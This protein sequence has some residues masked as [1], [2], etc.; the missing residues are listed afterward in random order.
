MLGLL[1][2]EAD[3]VSHLRRASCLTRN[4]HLHHNSHASVRRL[5]GQGAVGSG[6]CHIPRAT[7]PVQQPLGA[8]STGILQQSSVPT[9]LI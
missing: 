5:K 3:L 7:S 2:P 1:T 9:T 8:E 4:S 6:Q